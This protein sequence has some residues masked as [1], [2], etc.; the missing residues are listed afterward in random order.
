M[1]LPIEPLSGEVGAHVETASLRREPST[2]EES[3]RD[4]AAP[5][6]KVPTAIKNRAS[7]A[8]AHDGDSASREE[9]SP[10]SLR[11]SAG[12]AVESSARP[13]SP[14]PPSSISASGAAVPPGELRAAMLSATTRSDAPMG[15]TSF[16]S[17]EMLLKERHLARALTW[18]FPKI[19]SGDRQYWSL[20]L[21]SFEPLRFTLML[22]EGGKIVDTQLEPSAS[23]QELGALI[24]KMTSYLALGH[25][26][27]EHAATDGA[28]AR[29]FEI[30]VVHR[31]GKE[32]GG[33]LLD[34][35]GV[36]I[37]ERLGFDEP[38][39]GRPGRGYVFDRAGTE[40]VAHVREV[41]DPTSPSVDS[42]S[43]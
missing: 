41:H 1:L 39:G 4:D 5:L 25:F 13:H 16:G 27:L 33:A 36:G 29:R 24:R 23:V 26:A 8:G 6:A 9:R 15:A 43:P 28:V 2:A 22:S 7:P 37:V 31:R 42:P 11:G 18:V 19:V 20:P 14:A 34:P 3:A 32:N 12:P 40:L 10:P 30:R 38:D 17:M 21:R 35:S